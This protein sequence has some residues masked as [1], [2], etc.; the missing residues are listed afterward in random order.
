MRSNIKN[1][2]NVD[3]YMLGHTSSKLI[4]TAIGF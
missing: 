1:D 3:H 4:G 2:S